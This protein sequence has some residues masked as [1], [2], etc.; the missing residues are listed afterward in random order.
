[1]Q[2]GRLDEEGGLRTLGS[3][4]WT[5]RSGTRPLPEAPCRTGWLCDCGRPQPQH[6]LASLPVTT[7]PCVMYVL[8]ANA[9]LLRRHLADSL[10]LPLRATLLRNDGDALACHILHGIQVGGLTLCQAALMLLS[11]RIRLMPDGVG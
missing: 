11:F 3:C 1:M 8:T 4:Y 10:V 6:F 7:V 9:V 5:A 2:Q